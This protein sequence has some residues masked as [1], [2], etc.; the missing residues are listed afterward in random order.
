MIQNI[1]NEGY[2]AGYFLAHEDCVRKTRQFTTTMGGDDGYVKAGTVY[3]SNDSHAEGIVYEPVDVSDGNAAGSVV[4]AGTV[5]EDR[6]AVDLDSDAKTALAANGI[7][8][9]AESDTVTRPY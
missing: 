6:L 5:I 4:I 7:V 9:V 2:E 3:P 1:T 8:F